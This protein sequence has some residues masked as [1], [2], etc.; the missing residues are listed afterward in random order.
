LTI[1]RLQSGGTLQYSGERVKG[2][3]GEGTM[4]G[5]RDKLIHEYFGI[6]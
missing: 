4:A 6:D 5:M 1:D 3:R 2:A